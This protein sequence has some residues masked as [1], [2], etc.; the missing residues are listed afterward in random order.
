MVRTP[1]QASQMEKTY[2][3]MEKTYIQMEK[4]YIQMEKTSTLYM[5][6]G[7]EAR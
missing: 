6:G 2:I 3:Q 1:Q 4:T 7:P 5:V